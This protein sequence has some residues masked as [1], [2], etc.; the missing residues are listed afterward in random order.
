MLLFVQNPANENS[1]IR[2]EGWGGNQNSICYSMNIEYDR[3][4]LFPFTQLVT[5]QLHVTGDFPL[6]ILPIIPNTKKKKKG[7]TPPHTLPSQILI[8]ESYFFKQHKKIQDSFMSNKWS[9][10]LLSSINII[11]SNSYILYV[12]MQAAEKQVVYK[13]ST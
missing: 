13:D 2:K 12:I 11:I 1:F 4:F 9:F 6:E 3:L 10:L 5:C 8:L 7:R